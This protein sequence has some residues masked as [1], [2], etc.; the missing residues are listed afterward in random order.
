MVHGKEGAM[1]SSQ[2]ALMSFAAGVKSFELDSECVLCLA[3]GHPG[4]EDFILEAVSY[5]PGCF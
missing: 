3:P 2:E 4:V 1:G 5:G